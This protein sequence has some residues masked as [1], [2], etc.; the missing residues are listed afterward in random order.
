MHGRVGPPYSPVLNG[1]DADGARLENAVQELFPFPK[2]FAH[3]LAIF[4][5]L[6][7]GFVGLEQITRAFLQQAFKIVMIFRQPV[8]YPLSLED[9]GIHVF[10]G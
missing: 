5:L 4:Y 9:L 1:A 7:Q 3:P 8:S 10:I 2:Y 6:F